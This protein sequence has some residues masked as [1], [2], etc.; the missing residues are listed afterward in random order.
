M[1]IASARLA[2]AVTVAEIPPDLRSRLPEILLKMADPRAL[3]AV[4]LADLEEFAEAYEQGRL[5]FVSETKVMEHSGPL[6]PELAALV[7]Q[8]PPGA[9]YIKERFTR[10]AMDAYGRGVFSK[11]KWL[12]RDNDDGS[13]TIEIWYASND[14]QVFVP[15]YDSNGISGVRA[16]V[17]YRDYRVGGQDRQAEVWGELSQNETDE[18]EGGASYTDNTLNNGRNSLSTTFSVTN[19][20]RRRGTFTPAEASLRQRTAELDTAYAWQHSKRLG[21]DSTSYGIGLGAYGQDSFIYA[22]D[23]TAGGTAPRSDFNE[24]ANAGYLRLFYHSASRNLAFTPSKGWDYSFAAE[25]H[26]GG[27]EYS[28]A[29]ANLRYYVPQRNLLGLK[30]DSVESRTLPNDVSRLF[31]LASLA[32]QAQAVVADGD[33]P[34]SREALADA[35]SV[36]R[37]LNYDRHY[38]TKLLGLRGEYRFALDSNRRN[39]A[40][41]FTDH[42]LYGE[43]LDKLEAADTFGLGAVVRLPVYGGFKLGGWYGWSFDGSDHSYG[44][45]MGY[46]F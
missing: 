12:V 25:Q 8:T 21:L 30:P 39:E 5:K 27:F 26:F 15:M 18:P 44:I 1:A 3:A 2:L 19:Q 10:M 35:P 41:V 29:S 17:S 16:G 20:W 9:P 32:L 23:P 4:S 28:Q 11:L 36:L 40:F 45:A 31:P 38:G 24:A 13:V 43:R 34:Y 42:A 22:G 7:L 46:M 37:G 14:S 6:S 33:V